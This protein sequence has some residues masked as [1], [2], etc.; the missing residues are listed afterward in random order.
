MTRIPPLISTIQSSPPS[1]VPINPTQTSHP[2]FWVKTLPPPV[3]K[4]TTILLA[5]NLLLAKCKTL[6]TQHPSIISPAAILAFD[7]SHF[8]PLP[9]LKK[10]KKKTNKL[11]EKNTK[12]TSRPISRMA[13]RLPGPTSLERGSEYSHQLP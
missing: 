10:K 7:P 4:L 1:P 3:R 13:M 12:P 9:F 5:P 6:T 2:P 11:M 8:L